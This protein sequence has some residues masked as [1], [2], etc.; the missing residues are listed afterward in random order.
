MLT[1]CECREAGWCDRH[2]MFK[3][4]NLVALC[5]C[6]DKYFNAWERGEG[7]GQ[8]KRGKRRVVTQQA[9]TK[10]FGPGSELNSI[11]GCGCGFKNYLDQMNKWGAAGC[12]ENLD[13]IVGWLVSE[14]AGC[15]VF[16]EPSARRIVLIAIDRA[17]KV[18]PRVDTG[19]ASG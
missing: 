17:E 6:S 9:I 12:R 16:N 1:G 19:S 10:A 14:G 11:L 7:P 18:K 8:L 2:K 3:T 13:T 5:Q 4:P 15:S